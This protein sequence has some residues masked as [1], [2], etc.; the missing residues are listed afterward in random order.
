MRAQAE[1]D[2]PQI[3]EYAV[4]HCVPHSLPRETCY[5]FNVSTELCAL[6]LAGIVE[7]VSNT[8]PRSLILYARLIVSPYCGGTPLLFL[9]L[10]SMLNR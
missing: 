3:L 5:P 8:H 6:S 10:P 7:T 9:N 1:P 2:L 4:V